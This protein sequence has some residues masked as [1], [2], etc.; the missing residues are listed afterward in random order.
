MVKDGKALQTPVQTG[1]ALGETL[2]VTSGLK[3]GDKVVLRP[4][5]R[6][7][8]GAAVSVAGK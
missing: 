5:E 8:D 4:V 2:E 1:A 6:L 3:P 7:R